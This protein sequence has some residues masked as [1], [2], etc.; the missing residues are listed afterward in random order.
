MDQYH[1]VAS[2]DIST[3]TQRPPALRDVPVLKFADR[4]QCIVDGKD[5][6]HVARLTMKARCLTG[7]EERRP[8]A[9]ACA[10]DRAEGFLPG[11]SSA[12]LGSFSRTVIEIKGRS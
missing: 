6:P 8:L 7:L 12:A 9:V 3:P 1:R 11:Q 5:D 4:F 2:R 10:Y